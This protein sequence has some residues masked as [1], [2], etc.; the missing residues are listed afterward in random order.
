[1]LRRIAVL[2]RLLVAFAAGLLAVLVAPAAPA[3]AH[4]ALV[5]AVPGPGSVVQTAPQQIVITFSERVSLVANKIQVIGPDNRPINAGPPRADGVDVRIPVRTDVAR[6]TYLVSFRVVSADS[7]PVAASFTYSVGA[8]SATAPVASTTV[9]TN[10]VVA[11]AVSLG[12]YLGYA[13]L[14]LVVGPALVLFAL[15][16]RRLDRR[17]PTRLAYLG[18]GLIAVGALA[19]LLLQ[20]PYDAGTG[21]FGASGADLRAVF[22]T[23]AGRAHLARLAVAGALVFPLREHLAGRGG[24]ASRGALLVLAAIGLLTWPVA[25][26]A[27]S[28]AA[29]L[30]TIVADV[31]HLAA[32]SVWLGGLV[33]LAAFLLRQANHREL[34]AILPVWS[35]WAMMAVAILVLAGAA[36]ALIEIGSVS[37]LLGTTY[38]RLLLVKVGLLGL[39]LAVASYSHRLA[40]QAARAAVPALVPV[41]A[42]VAPAADP[43]GVVEPAGPA[44]PTGAAAQRVGTVAGRLR[45]TVLL[46]VIGAVL[47]V[48]LTSVLV[49]T[50]PARSVAA[51]G[52]GGGLYSVTLTSDLYQLQFD[53]DPAKVGLNEV[54]LYAYTPQGAPLKIIKWGGTATLE[55]GG[56]EPQLMDLVPLTDSHAV[57]TVFLNAA[58]QWRFAFTLQ[59]SKFDEATVTTIVPTK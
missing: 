30:L 41:P 44:D 1:M 46:E 16:P 27:G 50:A 20:A 10:T 36:Q 47:I 23:A 26:H 57:G 17:R 8:P 7:H 4:A 28:S 33:M 22:D 19:G 43:A 39:V 32:V 34:G 21:L 24:A 48:G 55:S 59:V 31:A 56:V 5:R 54:H 45:R 25:G 58:G 51:G 18:L 38:G 37:A 3:S 12:Q 6:G 42:G 52:S 49:Q 35:N 29:P 2:A 53:V 14:V 11:V 15:W 13:G 40:V 9:R